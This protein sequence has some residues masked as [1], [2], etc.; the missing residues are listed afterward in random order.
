MMG[1]MKRTLSFT[2][3]LALAP[4]GCQK[5]EEAAPGDP[6]TESTPSPATPTP[7]PAAAPTPAAA[8]FEGEVDLVTEVKSPKPATLKSTM[9]L[10]AGKMRMDMDVPGPEGRV[11]QIVDTNSDKMISLAHGPKLAMEM[12]ASGLFTSLAPW[13]PEGSQGEP[14][15]PDMKKTDRTAT[16]VGHT[17]RYWDYTL[18][19][20][21]RGSVCLADLGSGWVYFGG[22]GA[23]EW[24]EQTFGSQRFPLRYVNYDRAGKETATMEVTR[25]ERKRIPDSAFEV[26]ANYKRMDAS[27]MMEGLMPALMPSAEGAKPDPAKRAKG[28]QELLEKIKEGQAR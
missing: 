4:V 13:M 5:K 18:K 11:S 12:S 1:A 6:A 24:A 15:R 8:A 27:K 10:K 2:L 7:A 16:L 9:Q 21:E 20:G 19:S 28:M 14:E 23:T 25:L 17:C 26:P 3:C 22:P